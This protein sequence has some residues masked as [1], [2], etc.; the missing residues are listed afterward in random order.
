MVKP[1]NRPLRLDTIRRVIDKLSYLFTFLLSYVFLD[2]AAAA[3]RPEK[4][5]LIVDFYIDNTMDTATDPAGPN[6]RVRIDTTATNGGPSKS[7]MAH[8]TAHISDHVA[9]L[10]PQIATILSRLAK[11]HLLL[12]SKLYHRMKQVEK[13]ESDAD[14]IPRSA[15]VNFVLNLSKTAEQDAEFPAL[16]DECLRIVE[17]TQ[18]SLKKQII[19]ATNIEIKILKLELQKDLAGAIHMAVKA[20]LLADEK[21]TSIPPEKMGSTLLDRYHETLLSHAH[22]LLAD[23]RPIYCTENGITDLPAPY[24][25]ADTNARRRATQATQDNSDSLFPG[26]LANPP[27]ADA[28]PVRNVTE[29]NLA[30]NLKRTLES[31][32]ITTWAIYLGH[33]KANAVD[34]A[35]KKLSIEHFDSKATESAAME[36]DME[37]P[38]TRLQLDSL[39]QDSVSKQTKK[40]Q[41]ELT[42]IRAE[43]TK[44]QSKPSKKERRGS[45]PSA[46][47]K[48]KSPSPNARK[49]AAA[50][51]ASTADST[52]NK[53]RKS[54]PK[55]SGK[56]PGNKKKKNTSPRRSGP[57]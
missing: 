22:C 29:D 15:R 5:L 20:F 36:I 28:P 53:G 9:S 2:L 31:V 25:V 35:L 54:K 37:P 24:A 14:F 51:N 49:A 39:I 52:S 40:L 26:L 42:T 11:Q 6:K 19:A 33:S 12:L 44:T 50:A 27:P 18:N 45:S 43:L 4:R 55:S 38:A 17:E 56:K 1:R 3:Q 48:K 57:A 13:M 10:Q 46:S 47:N 41:R 23:F 16:R 8:A 30:S 21:A 34:A 32:F 7:P